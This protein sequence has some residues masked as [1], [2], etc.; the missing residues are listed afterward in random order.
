VPADLP[1]GEYL[2]TYCPDA[3]E[4]EHL[5]GDLIGGHLSV[6]VNPTAPRNREWPVDEPEIANLADGAIVTGPGYRTTAAAI[7]AADVS[8]GRS[9]E[10]EQARAPAPSASVSNLVD[11]RPSGPLL[12][13]AATPTRAPSDR[14]RSVVTAVLAG[15]VVVTAGAASRLGRRVLVDAPSAQPQPAGSPPA[16]TPVGTESVS[17]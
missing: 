1:T 17:A 7:R 4:G 14:T 16:R 9:P 13:P 12:A 8:L 10:P 5:L 15:L 3:C 11:P 6:G 2:L